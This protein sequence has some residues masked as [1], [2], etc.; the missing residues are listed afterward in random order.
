MNRET[1]AHGRHEAHG[2]SLQSSPVNTVTSDMAGK[3]CQT[4]RVPGN[5]NM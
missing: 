4:R 2:E 1:M 3:N 5:P